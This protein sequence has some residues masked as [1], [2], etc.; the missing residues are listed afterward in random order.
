ME[1]N[2]EHPSDIP[3]CFGCQTCRC[4]EK[5]PVKNSFFTPNDTTEHIKFNTKHVQAHIDLLYKHQF[6]DQILR[7]S[8]F[9]SVQARYV[10]KALDSHIETLHLFER[11]V[12]DS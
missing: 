12:K 3:E 9:A 7:S 4:F 10:K 6:A 5:L 11:V 2:I 8:K 1:V